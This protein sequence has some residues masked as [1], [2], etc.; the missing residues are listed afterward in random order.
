MCQRICEHAIANI[1][2]DRVLLVG[3]E[4]V[5]SFRLAIRGESSDVRHVFCVRKASPKWT[6]GCHMLLNA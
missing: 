6:V 1:G 5:V 4:G 3:I 2:G